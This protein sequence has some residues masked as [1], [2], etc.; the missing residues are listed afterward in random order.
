MAVRSARYLASRAAL[1]ALLV[2]PPA[3]ARWPDL[4]TAALRAAY[5]N[6]RAAG[7]E[8]SEPLA[9]ALLRTAAT[10]PPEQRDALLR[11]AAQADPARPEPHLGRARLALR[12]GDAAGAGAA[13][14]DAW[15]AVRSDA[16]E[17]ARWVRRLV[18][19][20]HAL[21][22]ATLATLGVLLALRGAP[23]ARHALGERLGT[24]TAV[25]LLLVVPCTAA[26]LVSFALGTVVTLLVM[27][28]FQRRTERRTLAVLCV[29]LAALD[30]SAPLA[31]PQA[32]LLDP[33]SL[34]AR[35][36]RLNEG[37]AE[38][39]TE[40]Q[41][42]AMPARPAEVEMVL[43]LQAR[44]RR[45][46][47]TAQARYVACLRAD[48]S[49]A[50]A[51]IDLSNLFFR[52]GQYERAAAGYRVAQA[53][54]PNDPLAYANLAQTYIRMMHYGEADR[55]LRAA[56]EHG[57][58]TV[59]ER[60]AMWRDERQPVLDA[61]LSKSE[62]LQL[63]RREAQGSPAACSTALRTWKSAPWR[64]VR[65]DVA[66]WLLLLTAALLACA[67]GLRSVTL[68]CPGCGTV[69]CAH[70]VAQAPAD[71][72][73][74]TCQLARPRS[75]VRALPAEGPAPPPRR[76][77]SLA[78]GRWVAGLFPGA[79]DLV[80]G[81]PIAA[82]V[83]VLAAWSGLLVAA[84]LLDAARLA[85]APWYLALDFRAL[86]LAGIVVGGLWLA[87]LYRLRQRERARRAPTRAPGAATGA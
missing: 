19:G 58:A 87:G 70:C 71:E 38:P 34:A 13:L 20:A 57:M 69:L 11:L 86:Q 55:E 51:Y 36:A 74:N 40:A 41:L 78:T 64:S 31:A 4:P 6:A 28:P 22:A 49:A 17:E 54:R 35:V 81:A 32:L 72:L 27:A 26:F 77:V 18:H 56:A 44:R 67:G 39:E 25:T 30:F 9:R 85:G 82:A 47:E 75:G 83:S 73:C 8:Q 61:T 76:R 60:R 46:F 43:G 29:L 79:A 45:D 37:A 15:K 48:S 84:A 68:A 52:S 5:E 16:R 33:R 80:R 7:V 1:L 65:P 2:A 59:S 24:R 62:L 10:A 12:G 53:M 63:A 50:A 42:A 66:P 3:A 21:L 14:V 23:L